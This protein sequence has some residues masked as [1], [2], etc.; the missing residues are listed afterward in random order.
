MK[1]RGINVATTDKKSQLVSQSKVVV[2]K[3]VSNRHE[4]NKSKTEE[5]SIS[6][7]FNIRN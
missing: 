4:K 5:A 2:R 6:R 3:L 1:V 7:F